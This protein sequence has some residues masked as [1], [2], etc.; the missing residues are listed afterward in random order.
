[1]NRDLMFSSKEEKWQT[2]QYIFDELDREFNFTLDPCCQHDSAKCVKYYTPVEDG[3]KQCW[4]GETVFVNPPYGREL[5]KWV[6]KCSEE[7]KH[8]TIVM[9][10]PSRTDTTYFHDYIYDKAEIRFLRG[11]IKFINPETKKA[12][13]AAPFGSMIVIYKENK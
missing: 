8:A 6:K 10:I 7:S 5:K 12:G 1:M 11:R 2:P 13:D 9:L 3:L 4:Q